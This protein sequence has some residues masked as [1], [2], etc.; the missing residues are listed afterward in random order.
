MCPAWST[1]L[2]T[3]QGDEQS[4]CSLGAYVVEGEMIDRKQIYSPLGMV[5]LLGHIR[6]DDGAAS[7]CV[8]G[9]QGRLFS[10]FRASRRAAVH[11]DLSLSRAVEEL[12][13]CLIKLTQRFLL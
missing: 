7:Y 5:G 2:G 10:W 12:P 3:Q 4:P 9:G 1:E 8:R 11:S 13:G 6:P